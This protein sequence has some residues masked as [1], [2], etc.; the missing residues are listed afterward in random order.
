MID[1]QRC[2]KARRQDLC[3]EVEVAFQVNGI[4][5]NQNAGQWLITVG[6]PLE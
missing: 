5:D 2:R 3:D 4:D 1:D 6:A